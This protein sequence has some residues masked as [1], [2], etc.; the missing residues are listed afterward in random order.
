[1]NFWLKVV[2]EINGPFVMLSGRDDI[3][4]RPKFQLLFFKYTPI[5]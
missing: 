1:M 2:E 4:L 5:S 3:N